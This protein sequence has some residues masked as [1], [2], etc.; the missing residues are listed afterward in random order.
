MCRFLTKARILAVIAPRIRHNPVSSKTRQAVLGCVCVCAC[1][2]V[3]T[4]GDV[5]V[6]VRVRKSVFSVFKIIYEKAFGR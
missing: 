5:R 3:G 6:P 4:L 1:L 2:R